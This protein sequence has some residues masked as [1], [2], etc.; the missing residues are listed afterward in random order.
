MKA[1]HAAALGGTSWCHYP[2]TLM[3]PSHSGPNQGIIDRS[4]VAGLFFPRSRLCSLTT[5]QDLSKT[6]GIP[7]TGIYYTSSTGRH[8]GVHSAHREPSQGPTGQDRAAGWIFITAILFLIVLAIVLAL[9][10]GR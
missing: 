7:G 1:R 3:R 4:P 10:A 2:T 5:R 8:T 9:A 6:V